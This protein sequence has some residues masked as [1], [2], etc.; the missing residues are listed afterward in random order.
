[1]LAE[2]RARGP[3]DLR[4]ER[5][6]SAAGKRY[7]C[8]VLL[9]ILTYGNAARKLATTHRLYCHG[10]RTIDKLTVVV[11]KPRTCKLSLEAPVEKRLFPTAPHFVAMLVTYKGSL[12][13][14]VAAL[15]VVSG[16]EGLPGGLDKANQMNRVATAAVKPAW[17]PTTLEQGEQNTVL[18]QSSHA[19]P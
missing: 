9:P 7:G 16:E 10:K 3:P 14:L 2:Q 1:M 19:F 13:V 17:K 5:A 18:P 8:S 12:L 4:V 11:H 15:V 6:A